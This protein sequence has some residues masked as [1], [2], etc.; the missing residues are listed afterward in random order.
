[1]RG[2][3]AFVWEAEACFELRWRGV[4]DRFVVLPDL[5]RGARDE[6]RRILTAGLGGRGCPEVDIPRP[7]NG[8]RACVDSEAVDAVF[9]KEHRRGS[10]PPCVFDVFLRE[11]KLALAELHLYPR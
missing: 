10:S 1:M 8:P 4:G 3:T 5:L 7:G 9:L 2:G 11:K 6:G